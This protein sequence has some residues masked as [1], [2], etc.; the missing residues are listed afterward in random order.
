MPLRT[1]GVLKGHA[2]ASRPGV[3]ASPH[4]QVHVVAADL[5]WRI[6]V[7]VKSELAPSELLYLV[8]EDF[9]HP[10][11]AGLGG[12]PFGHSELARAPGGI[13]LDFIRGN[14]FDRGAMRLLPQSVPGPD[15]DLNE[16]LDA[17][18]QRAIDDEDAVVYAFGER[19]GPEPGTRDQVLRFPARQRHP[20][21]PH[22]PGQHGRL[23]RAR[24]RVAGRRADHPLPATARAR[25]HGA[26][27]RT[28]GGHLPRVPVT[29]LAHRRRHGPRNRRP[30]RGRDGWPR[31]SDRAHS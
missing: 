16:K 5:Q 14:L 3:G 8:V 10:V 12:L 7:N 30:G 28:V 27:S 18:V 9:R 29:G 2:I 17:Y 20:R 23:R 21:H 19:W 13:A 4:Y 1:Y 25:R 31:P 24:R 11:T 26:L 6:A 15:N 22:E